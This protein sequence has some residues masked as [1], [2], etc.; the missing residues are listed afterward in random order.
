MK[1]IGK[2]EWGI[3][4]LA[5]I[6]MLLA[7]I[8]SLQYARREVRDGMRRNELLA[9]KRELEQY[10]NKQENYPVEYDASPHEYVVLE[11]YEGGATHWYLRAELEN[12]RMPTAGFDEEYNV[13]FRVLHQDQKTFYDICGGELRCGE[14]L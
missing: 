7:L 3:V 10:F 14:D 11:D 1:A 5:I 9:F 4:V 6:L 8:P 13:F 2:W 12:R